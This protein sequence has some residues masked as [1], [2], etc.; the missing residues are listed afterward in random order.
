VTAKDLAV[1]PD[2]LIFF[3]NSFSHPKSGFLFLFSFNLVLSNIWWIFP[4]N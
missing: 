1:F 4:N 3:S 2:W